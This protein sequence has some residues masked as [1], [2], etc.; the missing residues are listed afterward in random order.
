MVKKLHRHKLKAPHLFEEVSLKGSLRDV[1]NLPRGIL[2]VQRYTDLEKNDDP[3]IN[4]FLQFKLMRGSS[5]TPEFVAVL[6]EIF[7]TFGGEKYGALVASQLNELQLRSNGKPLTPEQ[8]DFLLKNYKSKVVGESKE[9]AL[10]LEGFI[11]L[12]TRQCKE[13]KP[14][15]TWD[16]LFKLGYDL[17][18]NRYSS[19][20]CLINFTETTSLPSKRPTTPN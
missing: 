15:I 8:L 10:T 16:E 7:N 12:Y 11:D 9:L 17:K 20:L 4:D 13:S 5:L 2:Q 1:A 6:T 3:R 14:S 19:I 18:L